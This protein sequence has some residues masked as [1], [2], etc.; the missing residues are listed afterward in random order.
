[1][2]GSDLLYPSACSLDLTLQLLLL[3]HML[4]GPTNK[5][6][7]IVSSCITQHFTSKNALDHLQPIPTVRSF[8]SQMH[9]E[10]NLI[11]K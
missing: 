3:H 9:T 4:S 5:T 7:H 11:Q 8:P 2:M 1:M 10:L 6:D